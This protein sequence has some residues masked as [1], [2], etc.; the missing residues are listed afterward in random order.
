[1]SSTF[2][3]IMLMPATIFVL[4][5]ILLAAKY[6]KKFVSIT[7]TLE[8]SGYP[9]YELFYIGFELLEMVRFN[10][11]S[12]YARKKVKEMSEVYGRRY[13]E[14]YYYVQVGGQV[15]YAVT[16]VPVVF[17]LAVLGNSPMALAF[18]IVLAFLC[19]WYLS[20][21]FKD[22]LTA[23]REELLADFPQVLSK[24]TLLV[25]SGMMLRNAWNRVANDGKGVLYQ[26]M[27]AA[28]AEMQNG[29]SEPDAYRNFAERCNVKEIR[30]FASLIIQNLKKGNEELAYFLKD[31]S[32]EMWEVKKN[33]VKQKGE[34]ANSRLLLPM[35]LIFIGILI[36]IL[37][38]VFQQMG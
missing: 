6:E 4:L 30:K 21:M 29:I 32:D 7:Q 25:N 15:T 23:R 33:E 26:E 20:E 9:L 14:Y 13:A 22:K 18:G 8:K 1:M 16:M 31:L 3:M 24:L 11:K 5:W 19:V 27:A 36:M 37:V 38:P 12:D 10:T 17:I 35:M 28:T 34:K 2:Q